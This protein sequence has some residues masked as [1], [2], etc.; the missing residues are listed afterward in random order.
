MGEANYY[1]KARFAT[2]KEAKAALPRL[3]DLLAEGEA[4]YTHWQAERR[5]GF[6]ADQRPTAEA[7]WAA[8]REQFPVVCGYLAELNGVEDWDNGLVGQLG[9]LVD[10]RR[11]RRREPNASLQCQRDTLYLRLNGIWHLSEMDLLERYC[12]GVLGAVT[13]ASTS[14][15]PDEVEGD[16]DEPFDFLD[17]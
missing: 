17:V 4:A 7:F 8:F 9:L 13:V 14:A 12:T 11:R 3:A 15:Y 2:A 16:P 10:P 6:P 5:I 1:L